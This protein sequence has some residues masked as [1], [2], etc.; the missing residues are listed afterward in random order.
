MFVTLLRYIAF[1]FSLYGGARFFFEQLKINRAFS[2]L[3]HIL[4]IIITLYVVAYLDW[5]EP[6]VFILFGL[7]SFYGCY[8]LT[9]RYLYKD[10]HLTDWTLVNL[11]MIFYCLLFGT[12]LW[13]T[14]L[15]HYDNFSHWA[16]I[17]KYLFTE[18]SLP[19]V[20]DPII[21]YTSYPMGTSL[22]LYYAVRIAGFSDNV[23]LLAQ[24][25]LIASAIYSMFAMIRD[26]SRT[27]ILS[28][29]GAG[30]ALF[31]IYNIS[32][33]MNNL[34]V[35]FVLPVLALAGISMVYTLRKHPLKM[36]FLVI[37]TTAVL[38]L[39]KSSG[40]FFSVIIW[41]YYL[42]Q[43]IRFHPKLLD[44]VKMA[45]LGLVSICISVIPILYWNAYVKANFPVTKHEV[46]ISSYQ[47]IF[48]AKDYAVVQDI[49]AKMIDYFLDVSQL[50][51]QGF[52]LFN[53]ILLVSYLG[54][55]IGIKRHNGLLKTLF[56][57]NIIYIIYY[58]GITLMF[59]FSMPEAEALVLA[60]IERY[61]SSIVI[62]ILGLAL[63][64]L[65]QEIDYS[66]YEQNLHARDHTSFKS[67]SSK[68]VYSLSTGIFSFVAILLLISEINGMKY[69]NSLN[70]E[71]IP[72]QFMRAGGHNFELNDERYLVV[73]TDVEY[74]EN[75][76]TGFVSY[77]FCTQQMQYHV[78]HF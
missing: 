70:D 15:E 45:G 13:I 53:I 69:L 2:W 48:G 33:R 14:Q 25:A 55:R 46:S 26:R 68:Q 56:L 3:T 62:F 43:M 66:L 10:F 51:T 59:L 65:V 38:N 71:S 76:Y 11:W 77:Y 49:L 47:S 21:S 52:I 73:T 23:M 41:L 28:L 75:Y 22:F 9:R 50:S 64:S 7:S 8:S 1:L 42:Y 57:G 61:T 4:T 60:G 58:I 37:L 24:F 29:M 39:V 16:V 74:L 78:R 18:N 19:T 30:I 36:S 34:L 67:L 63:Y 5:L 31:N 35:D 32:I 44:K 20:S 17:V 6:T 27:M 12:I 40:M 72:S 54:I